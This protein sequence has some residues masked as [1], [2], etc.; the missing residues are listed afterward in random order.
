MKKVVFLFLLFLSNFIYSQVDYTNV[1]NLLVNN[2]RKEARVLFDKQFGKTKTTNIDLLF[3]DAFIDEQSGRISFDETMLKNLEKLPNSE[4]YIAPFINRDIVLG[5]F[6][7]DACND[8][9]YAKMDYLS[10]SPKFKDLPIVKYRKAIFER[11]RMQ[12][13]AAQK[14][15]EEL[16]TITQWQYCGV[17]ENLNGSGL[18]IEYDPELY[19]KND[20]VFD[21][22][23]NGKIGWYNPK[24]VEKDGYQFFTNE[25]EYGNGI[26]Y[27]QTFIDSPE[28]KPFLLRFGANQGLKIF[29]NDKEIYF[30]Q[31]I[32]RTNLDAYTL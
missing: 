8:L 17:F 2:K 15:F 10:A 31:D 28:K 29:L 30:N 13:E 21:A 32:K 1:L 20:K 19:A 4:Y 24:D 11:K 3:L 22:N 25:G 23:S 18:D 12:F 26:I 14:T 27:A 9:T 5:D 6:S 16:G 7:T